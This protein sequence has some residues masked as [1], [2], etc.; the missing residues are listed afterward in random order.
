MQL[1]EWCELAQWKAYARAGFELC[2]V[3]GGHFFIHDNSA[4]LLKIVRRVLSAA[5]AEALA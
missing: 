1:A 5:D 3:D 4:A 2:G